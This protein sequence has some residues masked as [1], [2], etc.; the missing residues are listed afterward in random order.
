MN[1]VHT[2][3]VDKS[4]YKRTADNKIDLNAY[5]GLNATITENGLTIETKII[6]ARTR[7]GHLDLN[8]TPQ[9]GEGTRWVEYKNLKI[10]DDSPAVSV[11]G[12]VEMVASAIISGE[13]SNFS[14]IPELS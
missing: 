10:A 2:P 9:A 13:K 8:V 1:I 5:I 6:G 14:P 12:T 7:Y 11:G 3:S 4:E